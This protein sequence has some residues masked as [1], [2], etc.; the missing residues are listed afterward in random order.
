MLETVERLRQSN[1]EQ[2]AKLKKWQKVWDALAKEFAAKSPD[3]AALRSYAA[4]LSGWAELYPDHRNDWLALESTINDLFKD[5]M[6]RYESELRQAC[7]QRGFEVAGE[8]PAFA[9]DGLVKV[10]IDRE[11]NMAVV[12]GKKITSLS[13]QT[14]AKAIAEERRRLWE[15]PLDLVAF[16]KRLH[17]IY[18]AVCQEKHV[19]VGE[20]ISIR[21]IHLALKAKETKYTWELFAADI[22]R[23]IESGSHSDSEGNELDLAPVR[24]VR[25]AVYTYNR[26]TQSGRYLG[27]VRFKKGKRP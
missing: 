24:D 10:D 26:N 15:R 3:P 27:L 22:S 18:L 21:E 20:Y 2:I 25:Q 8:F 7:K 17:T 5:L 1:A 9:V 14:V 23:L 16:L 19:T 4:Q 12:N 11:R 13:L 6:R